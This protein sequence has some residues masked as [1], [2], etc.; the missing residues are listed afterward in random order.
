MAKRQMTIPVILVT[1]LFFLWGFAHNLNPILIPHLKKACQLS[2]FQSAFIDSAFFIAYFAVAL[3]AGYFMK[4]FGYKQGIVFG[5]L[6]FALGAFLFF[7][8]ANTR[9]Y[10]FFLIAL[11]VIASGLTFLETAANPYISVLGDPGTATQRLNLAQ[12]FNGLAA[13]LAPFIGGHYIL[14]GKTL[15]VEEQTVMPAN[16]LT[17]YLQS[18]ADAVK[19][20]YIVIGVVVLL[21]ALLV[22]R[23]SLP[24]IN[25][26]THADDGRVKGKSLWTN[27]NFLFGV[28]ALFLYV[29]A[30]VG[31]V[32]FF[33]RFSDQVAGVQEKAAAN[34]LS[35]ALL[36][37]MLGRFVGTFLMRFVTPAKLLAIFS[38]L[39]V[40]FTLISAGVDGM[41]AVYAMV[42]VTF[43]MSIMFPTIFSLAI[44]GLGKNTKQGSSILIMSIVGGAIVP[45]IMGRLS[46]WLSMQSAYVVPAACFAVVLLFALQN[47]NSKVTQVAA[48]H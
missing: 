10:G 14:S 22:S 38:L 43:L 25:E 40:I 41:F 28:V 31:V 34:L 30:Q 47:I 35:V 29:G 5:L 26:E 1:S 24:E 19:L 42:G 7:P 16:D 32:S 23:T 45:L 36:G 17:A 20:P 33:I 13:T 8:A 15:S 2:D 4:R 27:G 12:S 39:S 11:F 6:L 44:G 3:P 48:A 9:E 21:V 18:E 37:F 46:D